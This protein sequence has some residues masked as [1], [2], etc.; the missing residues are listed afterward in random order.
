MVRLS[1]ASRPI[2]RSFFSTLRATRSAGQPTK[3][4]TT[5]CPPLEHEMALLDVPRS[6]PTRSGAAADCSSTL[7]AILPL[8]D[9]MSFL[10][11]ETLNAA[12]QRFGNRLAM[13]RRDEPF[14]LV[15]VG[16]AGHFRKD[17]GHVGCDEDH[18]RRGLDAAIVD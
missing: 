6:I 10:I 12:C 1:S 2:T 15:G 18:E 16:Q 11:G 7:M 14:G 5:N 8:C 13:R 9:C 4:S 17:R 3:L